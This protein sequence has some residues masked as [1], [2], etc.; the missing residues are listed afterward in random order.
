MSSGVRPGVASVGGVLRAA[1]VVGLAVA[2]TAAAAP[3]RGFPPR[4]GWM[5]VPGEG[6]LGCSWDYLQRNKAVTC[7]LTTTEPSYRV[8]ISD[9]FVAV[10]RKR[11]GRATLEKVYAQP[12]RLRAPGRV[13]PRLAP[14]PRR[15]YT[16]S[17]AGKYV[18]LAGTRIGCKWTP[19]FEGNVECRLSGA[20]ISYGF[21]ITRKGAGVFRYQP[22]QLA[23]LVWFRNHDGTLPR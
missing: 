15:R 8:S 4:G 5:Y 16:F 14:P 13:P 23:S 2:A 1:V 9:R 11:D 20:G 3:Q 10:Y 19:A 18:F 21:I 6:D 7:A 17:P 12:G 22:S